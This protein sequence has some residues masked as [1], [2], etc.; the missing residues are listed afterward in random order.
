MNRTLRLTLS[1]C[2]VLAWGTVASASNFNIHE[3]AFGFFN[4][5]VQL[6]GLNVSAYGSTIVSGV[7]PFGATRFA[8]ET[9]NPSGNPF[10]GVTDFNGGIATVDGTTY[11]VEVLNPFFP[12]PGHVALSFSMRAFASPIVIPITTDPTI[13]LT[14][15][16]IGDGSV[17][18]RGPNF[19][20]VFSRSFTAT[21]IVTLTLTRT[22][23]GDYW[24]REVNYSFNATPTPEPATLLL[25]GTGFAAVTARVRLRMRR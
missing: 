19:Q 16:F 7:A 22:T 23:F 14:A 5:N 11:P 18:G 21:G 2:V 13:T 3:P 6:P 25:L 9:I 17:S 20:F 12:Q 24:V 15:P 1:L 8:G 10:V 4:V